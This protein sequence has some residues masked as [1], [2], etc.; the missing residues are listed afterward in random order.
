MVGA[1]H[2]GEMPEGSCL[3]GEHM[4]RASGSSASC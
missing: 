3:D 1:W 2:A 4:D